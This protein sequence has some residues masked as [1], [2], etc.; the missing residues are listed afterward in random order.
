MKNGFF[1]S[2]PQ[3]L[4]YFSPSPS[5][6][7]ILSYQLLVIIKQYVGNLLSSQCFTSLDFLTSLHIL[8]LGL[9][10]CLNCSLQKLCAAK[11]DKHHCNYSMPISTISLLTGTQAILKVVFLIYSAGNTNCPF[12]QCLFQWPFDGLLL[13]LF[14]L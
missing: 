7:Q 12:S 2:L 1:R 3:S 14:R 6:L 11:N 8:V 10:S 13:H 4:V 5:V 9:L